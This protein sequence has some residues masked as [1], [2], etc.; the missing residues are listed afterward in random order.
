MKIRA[1]FVILLCI[2]PAI[3]DQ[4]YVHVTAILPPS[5]EQDDVQLSIVLDGARE[6]IVCRSVTRSA[7]NALTF[8]CAL[9]SGKHSVLIRCRVPG[10]K[11]YFLNVPELDVD[12]YKIT[13]V[14]L[15]KI[16]LAD[17]SEPRIEHIVRAE[18]KDGAVRYQ[19]TVHNLSKKKLLLTGFG[20]N[21]SH[22]VS[23]YDDREPFAHYFEMSKD[24]KLSF[25]RVGNGEIQGTIADLADHPE[26]ASRVTGTAFTESCGLTEIHISAPV[27]VEL[28]ANDYLQLE[29]IIPVS[30]IRS[31]LSP[32]HSNHLSAG[33]LSK[34]KS[35]EIP[36]VE[37]FEMLG[38]LRFSLTTS[39]KNWHEIASHY[40]RQ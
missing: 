2:S 34:L 22:R 38:T 14:Q 30:N 13:E 5:I 4:A 28:P 40:S 25:P 36:T 29:L 21:G 32:K 9:D 1:A 27:T 10:Y 15:G 35:I 12:P 33:Q 18:A 17:S 20:V 37:V 39:D 11:P 19:I 8:S 23:C 31:L 7:D 16:Q 6:G 26:F 3:A 24:L